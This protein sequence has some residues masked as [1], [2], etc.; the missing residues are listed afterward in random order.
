MSTP[1]IPRSLAGNRWWVI[2]LLCTVAIV[3]LLRSESPCTHDGAFHYFRVAA[4]HHALQN[5][6]EPL[7]SV[8]TRYLPDL[9]FGYGY[10]FFNY[11]AALSYYL[12]LALHVTGLALPLALNLVYALSI[13]GSGLAAYLLARDLFGPRAGIVAAVAYVY[14]PYQ[15]LD[16][17][18]RANMPET[19]AL[20]LLPL[21]LR[22][23]RRLALTGRRRWLLFSVGSLAA[24]LLTH[25]ISS[26]LF[27]PFL[28]AYLAVLWLVHRREE[29]SNAGGAWMASAIALAL[30]LGLTAFFWAPALLEQDYA[31][32]HMS[33]VTRNNDFHYNFLGLAEIFALPTP[34]D[35]SLMNPPM[36]VHLGL[37]QAVLGLVGLVAGLIPSC[38][39]VLSRS[40]QLSHSEHNCWRDRERQTLLI[41]LAFSAVAMIWMSTRASLWLWEHIPLLPFVQFPWRLVGRA[42]LP[43]SLLAGA[44]VAAIPPLAHHVS[45]FTFRVSSFTFQVPGF[46]SCVCYALPI[47]SVALLILSALPYTYPPRGYCPDDPQPTISDVFA[48]EHRSGLV[49][50]DPEGSYFPVWVKQRPEGSPLEE[51]YET[52]GPV[53][54]FDET[55]LPAKATVVEA[56]YGANRARIVVET[57]VSFRARYLAFYFP[58]WRAWAD[59]EPVEIGA[60]DPEGLITFD[61]PAGRHDL[62]IRFG[63]TLI[64]T[65][66]TAVSLLSLA[67]LLVVA[68][69]Y[70]RTS[71][72]QSPI[73]DSTPRTSGLTVGHWPLVVVA[74]SLL[75]FKLGVVDM[76][77][78]PF[79]RPTLQPDDTLPGVEHSLGQQYADGLTLIGYDWDRAAAPVDGTLRFD[80]YWT[81]RARPAAR[82]QTVIHLVGRDGLRWSTP[83]SFRPRGYAK[84]PPTPTWPPGHYALDS[85][86][87][88]PLPGTPPGTYEVVLTTFDRDTLASLSVLNE[89]GQPTAPEL[90]L[91]KVTLTAPRYPV[92]L[93]E[94]AIR[95]RL[96]VPL[97]P[98]TLL[99]AEFDRGE[100]APGDS[101]LLTTF[102]RAGERP[103]LDL[104][105]HLTLL[106][107]DDSAAG[108]YDLPPAVRWHPTS[109]WQ[110]DDVWRGQH[111]L[112]LPANVESGEYTWR[113]SIEPIHRSTDLPSTIRITAPPH[114][115]SPPPVDV[116]KN[117]RLGNVATLLGA[118]VKPEILLPPAAGNLKPGDTLTATLIWRAEDT[119][120]TSYHVFLHLLDPTGR[121]IAQSDGIPAN[122]T[123]PTTGWLPGEYIADS[124]ALTIPP[125]APAGD[126]TLSAGLYVPGG[127]RLAAADDTDAV[128][129]TTITVQAQ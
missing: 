44:S 86:E 96:D 53:A 111:I 103:V 95:R 65:A 114:T 2:L 22:A 107:P 27:V 72:L 42:I 57:P 128:T 100:G 6:T 110:P 63:S 89:E 97:G 78:T 30:A 24:L 9:A 105:V 7:R 109:A 112:R 37:L 74:I 29:Q 113:L 90:T 124:R 33:H 26:L 21:A 76:V 98:V 66:S 91:G 75:A 39:T 56:D 45:R 106:A 16:A 122:W 48:Y 49:G 3:P 35:T 80:L 125:D 101:M 19:V 87:V 15:F 46:I 127:E 117:S 115:F 64:R 84:Y 81:A 50:V 77:D 119:P 118:N 108:E 43:V 104:T 62:V 126:Y 71:N 58:G 70:P 40:K 23:F 88:E 59:G 69:R 28:L 79:R 68:L 32:L 5:S 60:T 4:V 38:S 116:E 34:V 99:G 129:L 13:A 93:D 83:D 31:Q 123:R 10:P 121:L 25:N 82:Y 73:S 14:A 41:F 8:F 61:V 36:R 51:Q 47:A 54:R 94:L 85:H 52:G 11:R 102:W 18:L 17:L 92:N 12:A 1:R 67:I 55:A 20:P 120:L